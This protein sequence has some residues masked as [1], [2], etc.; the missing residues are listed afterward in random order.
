MKQ[1]RK[2]VPQELESKIAKGYVRVSTNMQKEDGVSL[3]T[4]TTRIEEYCRYKKLN[5]VKTY[6]D[7]GI[8]GKNMRDRPALQ[9]L[10]SNIQVGDSI[11]FCDLSRLGRCTVDV[12]LFNEFVSE[13][14]A[15][16]I[17]LSP[18]IDFSTPLGEMIITVLSGFNQYERKMISQNI[19]TNM[20]RLV[21]DGKLRGRA[22]FGYKFVGKDKDMEPVKEQQQVISIIID[23]YNNGTTMNR[24]A[25]I[26]N[27]GGYGQTLNIN[28]KK[29]SP[30][31]QFY[32]KT[33]QR[34]LIDQGIV[35]SKDRKPIDER[36]KTFHKQDNLS[37]DSYTVSENV[38]KV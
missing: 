12:I 19:S 16:L 18:D 38:S 34:I 10:K 32:H 6:E 5:L 30:N 22:P 31:P 3:E 33:I 7:A 27:T 24:I 20:Q 28:K 1:N 4:Q 25:A 15:K 29:I 36:I 13:K 17:C 35:E 8:S 21:E 14:G 9:D 37:N 26:L 2:N 23:L 11:V